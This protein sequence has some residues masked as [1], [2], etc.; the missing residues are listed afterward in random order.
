MSRLESLFFYRP[1]VRSRTP[2]RLV[3]WPKTFQVEQRFALNKNA[4][5][6]TFVCV[7]VRVCA[8]VGLC[9]CKHINRK[10]AIWLIDAAVSGDMSTSYESAT[11]H[12]RWEFPWLILRYRF[13]YVVMRIENIY[14]PPFFVAFVLLFASA[15]SSVYS[16]FVYWRASVDAQCRQ[17]THRDRYSKQRSTNETE[18]KCVLLW[19]NT[20]LCFVDRVIRVLFLFLFIA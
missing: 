19:L 8:A 7:C 12:R 15:V 13:A 5:H 14:V 10:T 3:R 9:V 4:R 2:M 16:F 1:L 6:V 11:N 17:R 18:T 20:L